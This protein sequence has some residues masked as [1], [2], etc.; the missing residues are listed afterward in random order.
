[1]Y[2]N[3]TYHK[4]HQW[5]C[6]GVHI[7]PKGKVAPLRCRTILTS[8]VGVMQAVWPL[9]LA[10]L[11]YTCKYLFI[12]I[13]KEFFIL[14][15]KQNEKPTLVCIPEILQGLCYTFAGM[16]RYGKENGRFW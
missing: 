2:Q 1:M 7:V 14:D 11:I 8:V 13:Y 9:P 4:W 5:V 3:Y 12:G 10:L 16:G 6:K 15:I